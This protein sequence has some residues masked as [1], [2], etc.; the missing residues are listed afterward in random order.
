MSDELI[1]KELKNMISDGEILGR[2]LVIS[3]VY[4]SK[5]ENQKYDQ[6]STKWKGTA[7]N[8]LKIRFGESSS[9]YKD[10]MSC[11]NYNSYSNAEFCK[12][13]VMKATGILEYIHNALE[14]GLTD[15]LF[16][17]K[18]ILILSDLL[19]QAYE[20][21]KKGEKLAAGIYGRI[22]LETTIKEFAG[23]NNI[24][25]KKFDQI[26]IKLKINNIIQQPFEHLLRANYGIGSWAAHGDLKFENLSD[27]EIKEFLTFIRDRVLILE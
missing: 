17:K 16:Y 3:N 19:D 2:R 24:H 7:I 23:K 4:S 21:L 1:L 8:L 18:E 26:I 13:N 22:V 9:Y 20:F 5:S 12:E 10:F 6:K 25:E 15:D 27:S 11:I 14:K